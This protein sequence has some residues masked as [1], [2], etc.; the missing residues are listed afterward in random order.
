MEKGFKSAPLRKI[1]NDAGFT[2]GAFYGYY[3]NKEELFY[4]LT[5]ET[6][7]GLATI[8]RSIGE[9][10]QKLPPEQM[11]YSMLDCYL[12]RLPELADYLCAHRE[13]M[14]LLLRCAEGTKYENFFDSF[15]IMNI[16][17]ITQGV[18]TAEHTPKALLGIDPGSLDLM[19]RGY[20]DML[21]H[22]ILETEDKETIIR[23]MR[24]V[25]LVYRNGMLSLMEEETDH[26]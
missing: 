15:R 5:D 2:L 7:Q 26:A 4:A 16:E 14:V 20:F 24:D 8:V 13:E 9:D 11:L 6:A 22:I 21:A 1:V 3:K 19:M 12:R 10:M 25:A 23:R 18:E 17:R